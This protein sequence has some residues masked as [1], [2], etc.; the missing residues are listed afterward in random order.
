MPSLNCEKGYKLNNALF[1]STYATKLSSHHSNVKTSHHL[2]TKHAHYNKIH[3]FVNF[4]ALRVPKL[5]QFMKWNIYS[6]I[7][8]YIALLLVLISHITQLCQN[9]HKNSYT[10][11]TPVVIRQLCQNP[12]KNSYTH[13]TPVVIRQLCQNP[14]TNSYTHTT[15]VVIG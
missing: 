10:H 3:V 1:S 12:H 13:T 4:F 7:R 15:P 9:T 6:H 2:S 5:L 11:T 14:H 8:V